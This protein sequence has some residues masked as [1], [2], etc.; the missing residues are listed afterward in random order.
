MHFSTALVAFFS[1]SVM[2]A[3]QKELETV[4]PVETV[5]ID[6]I[7]ES[8]FNATALGVDVYG[9]VPGDVEKGDGFI[10]AE[11]G[12]L[13]WAWIRAQQ[14]LPEY[15]KELEAQGRPVEK[16]Q[17]TN[18]RITMYNGDDCNGKAWQ[19]TSPAYNTRMVPSGNEYWYS[20]GNSIRG[21]RD[22]ERVEFRSGPYNG[23][24]CANGHT[25]VRGPSGQGCA[26]IR[27]STCGHFM[28]V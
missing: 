6:H 27:A 15:E 25:V 12:T 23:D 5:L 17:S 24:R 2:A 28:L 7:P 10:A 20:T 3:P 21:Y 18:I 1:A 14:D 16:R 26:N 9:D 11:E 8:V 4:T 19:Y 13:A 22:N